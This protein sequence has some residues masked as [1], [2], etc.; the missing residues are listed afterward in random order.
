[1][2]VLCWR[3]GLLGQDESARGRGELGKQDKCARGGGELGKVGV[4]KRRKGQEMNSRKAREGVFGSGTRRE[5]A[6]TKGI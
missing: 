1:M 6:R 5:E 4:G 2:F 3:G